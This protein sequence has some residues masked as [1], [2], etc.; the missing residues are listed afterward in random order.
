MGPYES[1]MG[2]LRSSIG[3]AKVIYGSFNVVYETVRSFMGSPWV[4]L[5]P[6]IGSLG[7]FMG[8]TRSSMDLPRSSMSSTEVI[9]GSSKIFNVTFRSS[10]D[11]MSSMGY[12]NIFQ[13][14]PRFF[15]C[16]IEVFHVTS[17]SSMSPTEV[18]HRFSKVP[19]VFK[20][21]LRF[22]LVPLHVVLLEILC[23][24]SELPS[25][26]IWAPSRVL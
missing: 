19:W 21:L 4:I 1:F 13:V 10:M 9:H 5:K 16:P 3:P 17:R 7:F 6:S 12:T 20:L 8:P 25:W 14:T 18:F 24:F 23:G 26:V 22:F 2:P 11:L 15:M